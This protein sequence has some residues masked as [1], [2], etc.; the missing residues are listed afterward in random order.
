MR[1]A[2]AR[3]VTVRFAEPLLLELDG[4]AREPV[5]ELEAEAVPAAVTI[6]CPA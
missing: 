6:A 2:S 1:V 3:T 5:R 4:G